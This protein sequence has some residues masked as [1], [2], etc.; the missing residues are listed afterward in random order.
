MV[1]FVFE[2]AMIYLY[3]MSVLVF[4]PK[5]A[6][7]LVSSTDL[8]RHRVQFDRMKLSP[9]GSGICVKV[10]DTKSKPMGLQ[11]TVKGQEPVP[12]AVVKYGKT[13]KIP[14]RFQRMEKQRNLE[15]SDV[16]L[17]F[18]DDPVVNGVTTLSSSSHLRADRKHIFCYAY[19]CWG[20]ITIFMSIYGHV[21]QNNQLE[22]LS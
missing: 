21:I 15:N 7:R 1:S 6:K 19:I 2:Q 8:S 4:Q 13:Y 9:R 18:N 22:I 11:I 14:P 5:L 10:S 3:T 20:Q 12:T 16:E 17:I